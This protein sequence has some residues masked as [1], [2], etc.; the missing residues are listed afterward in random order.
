[1]TAETVEFD[2]H[3]IAA[4]G[5]GVGRVDGLVVFAPRTAPGDRVR[6]TIER[7]KRFA[8]ATQV[9]IVTPSPDRVT[10]ACRHY[11]A[12]ACGGCQLQHLNDEAQ[13]AAKAGMIRDAFT[14]IAK[15]PLDQPQVRHGGSA[16]RYRTKLTLALRRDGAGW[17]AGLHRYDDPSAV[18]AWTTARS[19]TTRDRRLARSAGA[20]GSAPGGGGAAGLGAAARRRRGTRRWRARSVGNGPGIC[21]PPRRR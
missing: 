14:R 16:W 21:W 15:R 13:R 7:G 4:G 9:E 20:R 18:F 8:R 17:V 3:A 2:I 5:D 10:P 12:D 1:M 11:D 6:A 19:P